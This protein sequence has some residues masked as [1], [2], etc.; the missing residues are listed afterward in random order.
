M[1]LFMLVFGSSLLNPENSENIK[2]FDTDIPNSVMSHVESA[3]DYFVDYEVPAY[4]LPLTDGT[5]VAEFCPLENLDMKK[6]EEDNTIGLFITSTGT[7]V[8]LED[9]PTGPRGI[10]MFYEFIKHQKHRGWYKY[11]A[12]YK[13]HI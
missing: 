3:Y 8:F 6:L 11:A 9:F 12:V 2:L 7:C 4:Q 5:Q 1:K 13:V 10:K